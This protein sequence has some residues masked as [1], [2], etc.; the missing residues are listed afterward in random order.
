MILGVAERSVCALQA[1]SKNM[2]AAES[3]NQSPQISRARPLRRAEDYPLC[4]VWSIH[5]QSR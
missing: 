2:D 5:V 1:I 4:Q 3:S